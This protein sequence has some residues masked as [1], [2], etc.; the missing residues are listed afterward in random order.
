MG[1]LQEEDLPKLNPVFTSAD[2]VKD[3]GNDCGYAL[4]KNA[5]QNFK[6]VMITTK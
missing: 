6:Y 2:Q 5:V 3:M 4:K 1:H